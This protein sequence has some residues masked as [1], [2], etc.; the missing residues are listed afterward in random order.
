MFKEHL[1][2]KV[3]G[4]VSVLGELPEQTFLCRLQIR[5]TSVVAGAQAWEQTAAK[6]RREGVG[7]FF[8]CA[9]E[10]NS[11]P[12]GEGGKSEPIFL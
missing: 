4:S 2:D 7:G 6:G 9:L 11:S 3:R 5:S 8:S 1:S 12:L 10:Q